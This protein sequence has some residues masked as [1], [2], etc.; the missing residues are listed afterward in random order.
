MSALP[1]ITVVTPSYN[2]ARFL[3]A[4]IESVL[5]Q[6]YPDLEYFLIDGGSTDGSVEIIESYADRLAWWVSEPDRGQ[7]HAINKGLE[8]ATGEVVGWL[9][10]DDRLLPGALA[11][12]GATLSEASSAKALIGTCRQ[13]F[14]DGRPP[15][16]LRGRFSSRARLLEAW[17]PEYDVHQPAVWWRR[18]LVDA[19]GLLDEDLHL[20]MDFD[21]WLRIAEHVPFVE[22]DEVLA[23]I[24]RHDGAKTGGDDF[25]DY[26]AARRALA[27]R[28]RGRRPVDPRWWS[29]R[30][31]M[32]VG[33]LR[34]AVRRARIRRHR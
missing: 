1:R 12:I 7:S 18:E 16:L 30:A 6:G 3:A 8:R 25:G 29:D 15:E 24:S 11:T 2:Q 21:Y 19:V 28:Y 31:L 9:N 26:H 14:E 23:E 22:V 27:L 17:R 13:V 32:S 34:Q 33:A 4:T 20:V 5:G 10:S